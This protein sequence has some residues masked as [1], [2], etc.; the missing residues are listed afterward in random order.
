[1]SDWPE[2]PKCPGE[3]LINDPARP[4]YYECGYCNRKYPVSDF[5]RTEE[6]KPKGE[7][8]IAPEK[9]PARIDPLHPKSNRFPRALDNQ[10]GEGRS[11][12]RAIAASSG[13]A[14]RKE[15]K[16]TIMAKDKKNCAAPGCED[17][18][19]RGIYCKRHRVRLGN[20]NF[21]RRQ[22]GKAELDKLPDDDLTITGERPA[23]ARSRAPRAAREEKTA[24]PT[25][26]LRGGYKKRA[27]AAPTES[28][29]EVAT[30]TLA[31]VR[32]NGHVMTAR[33]IALAELDKMIAALTSTRAIMASIPAEA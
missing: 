28:S 14:T 16:E 18:R 25:R 4:G 2:C 33:E 21:R 29:P 19:G 6:K 10:T 1:M 22:E 31:A 23:R 24:K 11:S 7:P 32:G 8:A 3:E 15:K 12:T 27:T 30:P 17:E 9:P 26:M 20:I 13:A 5:D